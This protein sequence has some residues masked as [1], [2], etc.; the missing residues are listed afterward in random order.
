MDIVELNMN[1]INNK[2]DIE[3]FVNEL[4]KKRRLFEALQAT[5]IHLFIA[6]PVV[7]GIMVGAIFDNWIPVKLYHKPQPAPPSIY[8]YW[9]PLI[10]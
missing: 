2:G 5:E 1:G 4:R 8:E 6:A 9:M 7:A 10:K 3:N